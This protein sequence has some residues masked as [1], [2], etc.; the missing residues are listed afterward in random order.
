M[1]KQILPTIKDIKPKELFDAGYFNV[2]F[3][4]LEESSKL[5]VI[6]DIVRTSMVFDTCP[7]PSI[8]TDILKGDCLTACLIFIKFA[9]E[10]GFKCKLNIA[11]VRRRT[12]DPIDRIS[13]KHFVLLTEVQREIYVID[14]TPTKG[15]GLGMVTKLKDSSVSM[16]DLVVTSVNDLQIVNQINW[17]RWSIQKGVDKKKVLALE[18]D[19]L[20]EARIIKCKDYLNAW[21]AEAYF[22]L[23]K[24]YESTNSD[25]TV[26]YF[27]KAIE[28][29]PYKLKMMGEIEYIPR[30]TYDKLANSS[31]KFNLSVSRKIKDWE[32]ELHELQ[33]TNT[34]RARIIDLNSYISLEKAMAAGETVGISISLKDGVYRVSDLTPRVFADNKLETIVVSN[35]EYQRVND[36]VQSKYHYEL[37]L[38]GNDINSWLPKVTK[39][40]IT[41]IDEKV[42]ILLVEKTT[43]L[44]KISK[45]VLV[46]TN[47][48]S[49][50]LLLF[51]SNFQSL[52]II[53]KWSY[54]NPKF[55]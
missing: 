46:R 31:R 2:E 36:I 35:A 44:E 7:D 49:E 26:K 51:M 52:S 39:D 12:H 33:S 9:N 48:Y 18:R 14:P 11:I 23:G 3:N 47:S 10:I 38:N 13:T 54:A 8:D 20:K 1:I 43:T 22:S 40:K 25:L 5:R 15:F 19:I 42:L 4:N 37:N 24:Y 30:R 16:S 32:L 45:N 41:N 29:D 6:N 55:C 50:S 27:L 17:L 53:N 21:F 28:L 34:D